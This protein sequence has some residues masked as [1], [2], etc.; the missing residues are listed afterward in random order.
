MITIDS[1]SQK[2]KDHNNIHHLEKIVERVNNGEGYLQ[3]SGINGWNVVLIE[4]MTGWRKE[5][6]AKFIEKNV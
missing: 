6:R 5:A 3:L 1:F 4:Y 2:I